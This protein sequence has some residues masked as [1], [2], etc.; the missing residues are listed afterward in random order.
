MK[1]KVVQILPRLNSGGV[2]KGVID[3]VSFL[4]GVDHLVISGGGRLVRELEK[5]RIKHY[6][7]PVYKKSPFSLLLI[8]EVK[9][10]I[11]KEKINIIHARSRVPAWIS[12]FASRGRCFF[13]TTAHGMYKNRFFSQ[14]MGWGKFVIC[15][16]KVVAI[17][18]HKN[19]NVPEEKI[20]IIPRWVETEKFEFLPYEKRR[21]SNIIVSI[22]RISSSK[23]YEYL[24]SAFKKVI[25]YNPYLILK[26]V[27]EADKSKLKYLNYLKTLVRRFSLD[28]NV[29]FLGY[30]KNVEEILK[31]ARILVAPSVIEESF[32]RVIIEAFASG[33]PVIATKLGGFK[34]IV[35]DEKDG[36]LVEERD[37]DALA[38]GILRLLNDHRLSK[39]IT[40]KAR[41]KIEK[42]YQM[43][44]C[45]EKIG[46]VY[47]KTN[48]ILRILVIKISSLGDLILALPSLKII[49]ENFPQSKLF[50]LTLSK[51]TSLL[52]GCPYLDRLIVV[53]SNYKKTKNILRIAK[54]LRNY[55][56]DYIID[57]QNNL[58]SH[59]IAFLSFPYNSFGFSRKLGFLLTHKAKFPKREIIDPL[60]SQER[61]LKILGITFKEKKLIY[62]EKKPRQLFRFRLDDYH[63][64]IGI[65]V[66]ASLKWKT[67]V[68]P[69]K[70][71]K[72][73]IELIYKHFP[74]RYK[75]LLVG[76]KDSVA[77]GRKIEED[78]KEEIINLCGKTSLSD[79]ID[80]LKKLSVFI[81]PDT[82]SL[83]LAQALE[84]ETIG[85]FGPT[86]PF[87]HTVR[88]KSLHLIFKELKCSFC[89]KSK[90]KT[91]Q[92]M[93]EITPKEVFLKL[94]KILNID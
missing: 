92:C 6:Q 18:L 60:T 89:Y 25:R 14:V 13:L 50:L 78:L 62:W 30:Q 85:L 49:K 70:N 77:V 94:K 5:K 23:G 84:V 34:E 82:A 63:Y 4:K 2:E 79:L 64:Y 37:P 59:L 72:K 19:F 86:N 83:H 93:E 24:L 91:N 1:L 42:F 12:F 68:W 73:L 38:K 66:C 36:I 33:V 16:S 29:Q 39:K 35:E 51:Y 57:L 27:G 67:K 7:L 55:S 8:P 22:G 80:V 26:I 48:Q 76:D 11:K 74:S 90:C 88:D 31:E 20:I 32:G 15:P 44:N 41:E 40:L 45:L 58:A 53:D 54:I 81:S 71:I 56:F 69:L 43:Q 46:E 75:V 52:D 47:E 28:Y 10:I 17:H 3:L 21:Q 65:N 61:I 9:K 87:R